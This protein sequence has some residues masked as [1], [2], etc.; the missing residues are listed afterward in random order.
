MH[1]TS[2]SY[3]AVKYNF[4]TSASLDSFYKRRD[5]HQFSKLAKHK[6]PRGYLVA[7]FVD[8]D[9]NWIG[10]LTSTEAEGYYTSW[11][12]RQESLTYIVES[13]LNLLTD[14]FV[15]YFKVKDGQHSHILKLYRQKKISI[16]TLIVLNDC[17]NFFPIWDV[18]ITDTLVWP[19]IRNKC[20]KYQRLLHYDKKKMRKLVMDLVKRDK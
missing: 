12:K 1:F 16:E 5:K 7:N 2:P 18:K 20:L 19:S 17:L 11:L 15:S 6:D 8:G 9:A 10:D 14:E 3:D 4:R 13:D